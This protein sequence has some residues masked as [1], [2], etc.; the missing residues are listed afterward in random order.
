MFIRKFSNNCNISFIFIV[1]NRP[2]YC[3]NFLGYLKK[4]SFL[5]GYTNKKEKAYNIFCSYSTTSHV[6]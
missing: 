3:Y 2:L 4:Y 1:K 6:L 5:Q